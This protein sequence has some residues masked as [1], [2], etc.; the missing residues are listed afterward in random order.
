[1]AANGVEQYRQKSPPNAVEIAKALLEAGA[2]V[3]A[4]AEMF[5]GGT[6][7]TTMNLLISS[8]HPREVC[9]QVPLVHTRRHRR[10]RQRLLPLVTALGFWYGSAAAA[11]VERGARVDTAA[12]AA[13]I[14]RLG[15]VREM[16]T[17]DG[18]PCLST[19]RHSQ[20][21]WPLIL[22]C[23]SSRCHLSLGRAR[24]RRRP[25]A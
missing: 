24:R 17:A 1:M 14:G 3:D 25:A 21:R 7:K 12:T 8:A 4:I 13:G 20:W 5:A 22:S 16:V 9:V 18:S 6:T 11:L 15:L 2:E 23:T 19:A 10:Y